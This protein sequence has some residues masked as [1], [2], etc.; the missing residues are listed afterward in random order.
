MARAEAGFSGEIGSSKPS[1]NHFRSIRSGT[2]PKVS[3][4]QKECYGEKGSRI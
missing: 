2:L 4:M 3:S 1:M